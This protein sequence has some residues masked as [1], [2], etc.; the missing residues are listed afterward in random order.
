[1]SHSDL[2]D[3]FDRLR[4]ARVLVLGDLILDR[5]TW[6]NARRVSPEAPV[7]VLD[8]QHREHRLGGAA[9]VCQMLRGLKAEVH[10]AGVVGSDVEAQTV[11][12]MLREAEV[13]TS[14]VVSDPSRPTTLKERF[15]GKVASAH[16]HQILRVDSESCDP[17]DQQIEQQIHS[18]LMPAIEEF[19]AILISD[20]GKGVCTPRLL[21]GIFQ[22][23]RDCNVP[24]IVDPIRGG[25]YARYRG[26]TTMTPN[27]LETQL[28]TSIEVRCHEDAVRAGV[29]LCR[30]A[31][32]ELAIVTLDRDGMTLVRPDGTGQNFPVR[33]RAVYD[34]TGAGDMVLAMIGVAI[35]SGLSPETAIQLANL[36]ASLEIEKIGVAVVPSEEIRA[37]LLTHQPRPAGKQFTLEE[38]A[39]LAESH[40][41]RDQRVVLTNGCFD[42]L[43]VGHV[44]YLQEAARM[45][46]ILIVAINSDHGVTRLKGPNRPV[47]HQH[48]RAAMLAA[49]ECVDY[50]LV[51]EED[52][53]HR[54]LEAIRPDI[55]VKGG[56]YT[57]EEVVGHEVVQSYGGQ[58]CLTGVVEGVSTTK[59]VASLQADGPRHTLPAQ[60][61][62]DALDEKTL[63]KKS[64]DGKPT[65][66]TSRLR[67]AG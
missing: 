58:I 4:P 23:A 19:G 2:L 42:L 7:I 15:V 37:E 18:T 60:Q 46:D 12:D 20:Y 11:R 32:L 10:C 26:A 9:N 51:F 50:V 64:T 25:D 28:A 47:I 66:A 65:D 43:H 41:R 29:E 54:L 1:M 63:D 3:A 33:P 8:S 30:Q 34:I 13:H 53:P 24:V 16:P 6:G 21:R 27:R 56:T 17:I 14:A 35:A 59:I 48:D 40:R 61:T 36:A 45:G 39:Q 44:S 62:H 55:L 52:T 57:P 5:Y 67:K 22:A 38:I 31:D 49:L